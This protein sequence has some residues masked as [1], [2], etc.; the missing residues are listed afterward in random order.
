M[1]YNSPSYFVFFLIVAI[2]YWATPSHRLRLGVLLIASWLFYAAWYPIYLLLFLLVTFLNYGAAYAVGR[3]RE[4]DPGRARRIMQ[5]AIV[6][7]LSNLAFFKYANFFLDT[8]SEVARS[9]GL[10]W[11]TGAIDVFLPLGISFYTFQKIAYVVDVFRGDAPVIRNPL[12][13]AVF[14]GFFPQLIAGPIVRPNEFIPQLAT[15][16]RFDSARFLHGLDLIVIGLF[17]KVLVADQLAPFS[18]KVF[19]APD[20]LGSATL[21]LGIYAYTAQIYCDFSGYTDIGRGC[22]YC[23]GYELPRNFRAPYLAV[24]LTDFWR[25]W[26]ITLSHWLRDYLYIPLGGNRQGSI[27]TYGNLLITMTLGGLW[28]GASWTFVIWGMLHGLGLAATRWAHERAGVAPNDPLFGGAA[29]RALSTLVTFHFVAFAWVFFRAPDLDTALTVL[30]GLFTGPLFGAS[31]IG[32]FGRLPLA[33]VTSGLLAA[34][35]LH[36]MAIWAIR[37]RSQHG[38]VWTIVRPLA[39]FVVAAAVL[40][41]ANR[42]PQQFIYF[43]F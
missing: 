15:I 24:N 29:Y 9:F 14:A 13:M 36:G 42:G 3:H 40:L 39:Y 5:V 17:K 20:G 19:G 10:D 31:D 43:Q 26:H 12:K 21:L 33:L 6:A 25:R 18:D 7:N 34:A 2:A 8:T 16:R 30:S 38:S 23:L 32:V 37:A 28:H 27:R 35:S 41:V 22:A 1:L 4:H 11:Q